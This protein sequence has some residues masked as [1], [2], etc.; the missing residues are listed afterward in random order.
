MSSVSYIRF[1]SSV[2]AARELR[3]VGK[4]ARLRPVSYEQKTRFFHAA[5]AKYVA[6]WDSY[7][8]QVIFEFVQRLADPAF[9]DYLS[10]HSIVAPI[11]DQKLKKF[12]TPNWE[13]S[14]ELLISC[15]GY[16]PISDWTW[17]KAQL[18]RQQSQDFLNGILKVRHSFAHGFA[19]PTFPWTQTPSGRIQ[20]SDQAL[21]R[22]E[23]FLIHLVSATD[24]GLV[25][26][27]ALSFPQRTFW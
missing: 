16:D 7:L 2:E 9:T 1:Q 10:L 15:T 3:A 26:H 27:G 19:I 18:N 13:N 6:G 17:R 23:R 20:L 22:I 21:L 4:D 25:A 5:L 12:N 14:R 24:T 8:N 11:V